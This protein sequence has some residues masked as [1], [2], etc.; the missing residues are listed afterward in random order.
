MVSAPKCLYMLFYMYIGKCRAVWGR[1]FRSR[2]YTCIFFLP[3]LRIFSA[4]TLVYTRQYTAYGHSG[5]EAV[6]IEQDFYSIRST[7]ESAARQSAQ[8]AVGWMLQACPSCCLPTL[9]CQCCVLVA[10]NQRRPSLIAWC[11]LRRRRTFFLRCGI[12]NK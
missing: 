7:I 12:P 10:P 9:S 3:S 6:C 5:E 8:F 2:N 1:A 11:Q 4:Q